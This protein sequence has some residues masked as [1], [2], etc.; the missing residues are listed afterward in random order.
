MDLNS[1]ED[2]EIYTAIKD[3]RKPVE[4]PIILTTHGGLYALL[5]QGEKYADYRIL[6]FDSAWRYKSFNLYL[7]RPYDINYTLNYLDM[8]VYKYRLE[9]EYGRISK[10]KF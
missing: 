10:E 4:Y 7:S 3:Q 9:L 2:Y 8:L 5:E 6:F 1:K